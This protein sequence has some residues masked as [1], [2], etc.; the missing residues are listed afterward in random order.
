MQLP[1]IETSASHSP[2]AH[3]LADLPDEVRAT[4]SETQLAALAR[5][6]RPQ[7][8]PASTR[9]LVDFRVSIPLLPAR[10]YYVR[11]LVGRERRNLARLHGE[12]QSHV[13]R[14][15]IFYGVLT[16]LLAGSML[17]GMFCA[18]YLLKSFSGINLFEGESPLHPLYILLRNG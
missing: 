10:R 11:L 4:F 6:A 13:T 12:G 14:I 1:M 9:H 3:L 7:G 2:F 8:T 16:A 15:S 18:L 17:F 5:S